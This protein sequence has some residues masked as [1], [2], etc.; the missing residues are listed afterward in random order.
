MEIT[1]QSRFALR[2]SSAFPGHE[3]L[4]RVHQA[5]RCFYGEFLD[6]IDTPPII[7]KSPFNAGHSHIELIS[8]T[9]LSIRNQVQTVQSMRNASIDFNIETLRTVF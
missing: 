6:D 1:R 7:L 2:I 9:I 8:S 5:W 4:H 3:T